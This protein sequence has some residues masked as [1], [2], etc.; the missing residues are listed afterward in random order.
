MI[1]AT[2][3]DPWSVL[4]RLLP[5]IAGSA[6]IV[7]H[8]PY[9]SVRI[10]SS[11]SP[12]SHSLTSLLNLSQVLQTTYLSLKSSLSILSPLINEPFL[13][14]YQ[15]LPGRLH[16]EMQGLGHGGF[17]LSCMRIFESEGARSVMSEKRRGKREADRVGREREEGGKRVKVEGEEVERVE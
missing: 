14:K 10:L 3:Y 2:E 6:S 11:H 13:R 15:V 5:S 12:R 8:S 16:P 1:I 9:L 17:L 4:E 7:I